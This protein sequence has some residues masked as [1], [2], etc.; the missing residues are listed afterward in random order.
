MNKYLQLD[1]QSVLDQTWQ[2][3]SKYLADPPEIPDAGMQAVGAGTIG[4][5]PKAEGTRPRTTWT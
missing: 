5:S 4:A 2:D 3:F 1:D